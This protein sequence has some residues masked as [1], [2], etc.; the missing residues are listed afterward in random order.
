MASHLEQRGGR[1][2]AD[3]VHGL[4]FV[5]QLPGLHKIDRKEKKVRQQN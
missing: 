5:V 4:K 1:C 2:A 3:F